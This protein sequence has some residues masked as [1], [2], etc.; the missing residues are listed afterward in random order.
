MVKS[1]SLDPYSSEFFQ[2]FVFHFP[3]RFLFSTNRFRRNHFRPITLTNCIRRI[4]SNKYSANNFF[5]RKNMYVTTS[6][7]RW[8]GLG[9][10]VGDTGRSGRVI[11][12]LSFRN[13]AEPLVR[14]WIGVESEYYR[15]VS[16][17]QFGDTAKGRRGQASG[18]WT[19]RERPSGAVEG[20]KGE[21]VAGFPASGGGGPS[22][23]PWVVRAKAHNAIA[24]DTL[25]CARARSRF[26]SWNTREKIKYKK[27]SPPHVE[28]VLSRLS[29][30][31]HGRTYGI[32][33]ILPAESDIE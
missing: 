21:A 5:D 7:A 13:S 28:G 31:Q 27:K 23:V 2:T 24:R 32:R 12:A 1:T 6:G 9:A 20:A 26:I 18:R 30:V 16:T 14:R 8:L 19:K 11:P 17:F 25:G 3:F 33:W 15:T 4:V 22:R 10:G 29:D